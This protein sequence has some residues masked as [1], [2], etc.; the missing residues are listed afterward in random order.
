MRS[1]TSVRLLASAALAAAA[2]AQAEIPG[3]PPGPSQ[4]GSTAPGAGTTSAP[5]TD[6]CA[7]C[8]TILSIQTTTERQD[9]TPL[10]TVAPGSV[11]I[12]GAGVSE[13]RTAYIIGPDLSNKGLVLLGAAGGAAY[14]KR[15]NT[16]EKPRWDVTLKLD[17]GGTRVVSQSYE[18][19]FREGDR[20]RVFG[21]QLELINP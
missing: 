4:P 11:S 6:A 20:V 14:G 13:G 2:V 3:L 9:W 1:R 7:N 5:L 21:T 17:T 10:G 19:L 8:A 16:Y 12:A 15:S 18:P